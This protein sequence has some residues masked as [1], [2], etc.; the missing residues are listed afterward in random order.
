MLRE[1]EVGTT[2]TARRFVLA[3][4]PYNPLFVNVPCGSPDEVS[5]LSFFR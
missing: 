1:T 3:K 5:M 4:I 2:K